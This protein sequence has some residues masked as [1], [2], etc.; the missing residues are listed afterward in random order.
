MK[1][2]ILVISILIL[3]I[4]LIIYVNPFVDKDTCRRVLSQQGYTQIKITGYR[5]FMAGQDETTSTGFT[6]KSPSGQ[7]VSGAVTSGPFKGNTIRL[8]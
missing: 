6:A 3:L 7:Y 1:S 4:G 2:K 5:F 8:D